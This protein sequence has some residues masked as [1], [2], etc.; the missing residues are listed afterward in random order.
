MEITL[1]SLQI[2]LANVNPLFAQPQTTGK[3]NVNSSDSSLNAV[4][5]SARIGWLNSE[6]WRAEGYNWITIPSEAARTFG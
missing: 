2:V 6:V 1:V 4:G 3:G 5:T